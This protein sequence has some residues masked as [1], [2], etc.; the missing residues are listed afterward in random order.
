MRLTNAYANLKYK[1]TQMFSHFSLAILYHFVS[2]YV[3]RT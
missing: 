1:P 2:A 3:V